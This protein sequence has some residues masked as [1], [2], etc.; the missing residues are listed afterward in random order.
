MTMLTVG[1]GDKVPVTRTGRVLATIWMFFSVTTISG[2]TAAIAYSVTVHPLDTV[3]HGLNELVR[4]AVCR[5]SWFHRRAISANA[6]YPC[7]GGGNCRR[8]TA[9]L[10][11]GRADALVY[12]DPLLRYLLR[13]AA[14]G[15]EIL[16]QSIERQYYAFGRKPGFARHEALDR[17][18]LA[19]AG[20]SEWEEILNCY[21][22]QR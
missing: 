8:E 18:L 17:T 6:W 15:I 22:G 4:V 20:D 5:R 14:P 9:L 13:D 3:V 11:E 12:D 19:D 2:F 1:D 21:P 10:R 7:A 16:P